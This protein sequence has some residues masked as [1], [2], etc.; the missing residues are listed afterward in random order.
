MS[1][2]R[3]GIAGQADIVKLSAETIPFDAPL[4]WQ[5]APT[6][7][8]TGAPSP[9]P[10]PEQPSPPSIT[11]SNPFHILDVYDLPDLGLEDE[12]SVDG[13]AAPS[14]PSE[15]PEKAQAAGFLDYYESEQT[16]T[17]AER[18]LAFIALGRDFNALREQVKS[19]WEAYAK[20]E[21][22][23]S[24]LLMM[25]CAM[26]GMDRP[27]PTVDGSYPWDIKLYTMADF[28]M[29]NTLLF[30][31]GWINVAGDAPVP[32]YNGSFGWYDK[33]VPYK[34]LS[35]QQQFEADRA[36]TLE[37]F[38]EF[39]IVGHL[40][41]KSD[42]FKL[43]PPVLDEL[44]RGLHLLLNRRVGEDPKPSWVI[45][46]MTLHL[47]VVRLLGDE[48]DRP[49]REMTVYS[50]LVST[51]IDQHF[52]YHTSPRPLRVPGLDEDADRMLKRLGKESQYWD[53]AGR[54]ST[55][56]AVLKAA[57]G[58]ITP[59]AFLKRHLLYCGLWVADMRVKLHHAGLAVNSAF[60]SILYAGH[61]YN[62]LEAEGLIPNDEKWD[63][64]ELF[65][66]SQ[67]GRDTFFIGQ[68]PSDA[69]QYHKQICMVMGFSA[70]NFA[71]DTRNK[72]KL[73]ETA[74]GPRTLKEQGQLSNL[75]KG[76][77]SPGISSF[78]LG[79]DDVYNILYPRRAAAG[80]TKDGDQAAATPVHLVAALAR[81]LEAEIPALM[82]DYFLGHRVC[83]T[84]FRAVKDAIENML[85]WLGPK[86]ITNEYQLPF[87]AGFIFR[88]L[89]GDA[90]LPPTRKLLGKAAEAYR[91]SLCP[92]ESEN[93]TEPRRVVTN[94]MEVLQATI[95][96]RKVEADPVRDAPQQPGYLDQQAHQDVA[97]G[98]RSGMRSGAPR[99]TFFSSDF[100]DALLAAGLD[101]A[102]TSQDMADAD[103]LERASRC[104][105]RRAHDEDVLPHEG[106]GGILICMISTQAAFSVR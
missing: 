60:G 8:K 21:M 23:L 33:T 10:A 101:P 102:Q 4:F 5:K 27:K 26:R 34:S 49:Y 90:K 3:L 29:L 91:K 28:C 106:H 50:N 1:F 6:T 96:L 45:L 37:L 44:S 82:P 13:T 78:D 19:L 77:F 83:W 58:S 72:G 88:S 104:R 69:T 62:A 89:G 98:A 71:P 17:A 52:D 55:L 40:A 35:N 63:D 73:Q 86:W 7:S 15:E 100:E 39:D 95:R 103:D 31:N 38:P 11:S 36:H 67:G 70:G 9:S 75:F 41:F 97:G 22:S 81:S 92:A 65:F 64:M 42:N 79:V 16:N 20:R 47:D 85:Q 80:K 68:A 59:T 99:G 94:K 74:E 30:L 76:Q 61:L 57:G 46:A 18:F 2:L 51:T 25:M 84:F 12:A 87:A 105:P 43:V 53:E 56:S 93:N 24:S 14:A 32:G 66:K 54:V 48:I